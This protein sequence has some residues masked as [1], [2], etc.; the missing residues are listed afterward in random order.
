MKRSYFFVLPFLSFFLI[1]LMING[2]SWILHDS[3]SMFLTSS[4]IQNPKVATPQHAI[5]ILTN[6]QLT[7]SNGITGGSGI[8]TDP[9]QIT[10]WN[11]Y[12]NG[13]TPNAL[14]IEDTTAY[15]EISL[16]TFENY[17]YGIKL[18]NCSNIVVKNCEFINLIGKNGKNAVVLGSQIA[19]HGQDAIGI[20]SQ[21]GENINI[22][23]NRMQNFLAGDSQSRKRQTG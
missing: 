8:S 4:I 18:E 2:S 3:E 14:Y 10:G 11:F 15:I 13:S 5:S 6:A 20:F 1:S 7:V 23:G 12:G 19:T 22:T 9:F 21:D 16:C 17:S